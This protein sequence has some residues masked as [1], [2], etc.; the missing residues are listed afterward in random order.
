VVLRVVIIEKLLIGILIGVLLQALLG[1]LVF[2]E[3]TS[4]F[5]WGG[6]MLVLLGLMLI[7]KPHKQ[8]DQ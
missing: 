1:H 2:G 6:A 4:L 7:C 3:V 5:W 8:H